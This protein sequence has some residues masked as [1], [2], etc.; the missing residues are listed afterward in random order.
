MM[1]GSQRTQT[2]ILDRLGPCLALPL[3]SCVALGRLLKLSEPR[4]IRLRTA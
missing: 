2:L 3:S 1:S 4:R